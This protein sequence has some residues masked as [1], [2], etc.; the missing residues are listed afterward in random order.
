[1][2]LEQLQKINS[3]V[4]ARTRYEQILRFLDPAVCDLNLDVGMARLDLDEEDEEM[5]RGLI[6]SVY[7]RRL[8]DVNQQ[9]RE[10]GVEL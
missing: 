6:H 5:I 8:R 9:L 2:T 10:L 1:M 4:Q 3:L 7:E